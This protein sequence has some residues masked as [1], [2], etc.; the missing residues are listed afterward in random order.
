[1]FN[2]PII[3]SND[4]KNQILLIDGLKQQDE[5]NKTDHIDYSKIPQ[6][7]K[8]KIDLEPVLKGKQLKSVR[9]IQSIKD[10]AEQ[11]YR[12]QPSSMQKKQSISNKSL[13][14]VLNTLNSKQSTQTVLSALSHKDTE[15]LRIYN[16]IQ[17]L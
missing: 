17:Y 2:A 15:S 4:T 8:N 12:L 14:N 1:M 9:S 3:A 10:Y 16:R 6:K 11:T 5:L 13:L 7:A